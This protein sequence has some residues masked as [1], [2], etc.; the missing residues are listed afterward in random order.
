MGPVDPPWRPEVVHGELTD[1]A[2]P[3][4]A[5]AFRD[6]LVMERLRRHVGSG[7]SLLEVACGS[8]ILPDELGDRFETIAGIDLTLDLTAHRR[9]NDIAAIG[10]TGLDELPY[11][12]R[13]FDVVVCRLS[14]RHLTEPAVLIDEAA[15]VLRPGGTAVIVDIVT[16]D[17]PELAAIHNALESLR[18]PRHV[19]ALTDSGVLALV[20]DAGL[21]IE[22]TERWTQTLRFD[23]WAGT[24]D[25]S[26]PL[27]V[28]MR[29]LA[30]LDVDAGMH[31]RIENGDLMLDQPWLLVAADRPAIA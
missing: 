3:Q 23:D 24:S 10:L 11:A 26:E 17:D 6:R 27:R 16:S 9:R 4:T 20:N 28:V 1:R 7:M 14:L 30:L 5:P 22:V 31:L 15:R 8:A 12:S 19:R 2:E 29:Q 18:D 21:R 13:T 25:V